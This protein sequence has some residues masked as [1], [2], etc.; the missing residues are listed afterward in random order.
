MKNNLLKSSLT[1]IAVSAL[2]IVTSRPTSAA[3]V[4]IGGIAFDDAK[5]A[6]SAS[7]V[8]G[9]LDNPVLAP[10]F[11]TSGS[12]AGSGFDTNKT[13]G[14]LLGYNPGGYPTGAIAP[15]FPDIGD[16]P[17]EPNV[18]RATIQ[19]TLPSGIVFNGV[20]DDFIIY[21]S[22]NSGAPE[23]FAV[24][25]RVAGASFSSFRYEFA[26]SFDS[27]NSA[28]ATGFDLANFGVADNAII[29]A[30]QI[31][32]IFSSDRVSDANGEGFV[33]Y[34]PGDPG[35]PLLG[36]PQ[37]T[38]TTYPINRLDADILYVGGLNPEPIVVPFEFS[39]G[40]GLLILSI[41][42]GF[43]YKRIQLKKSNTY[44]R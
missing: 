16:A 34:N 31:R 19:L 41:W 32:N 10:V 23:G 7:I 21:E 13:V 9:A 38:F 5:S 6:T 15:N 20:G 11:G 3:Q 26:N 8:E 27:A 40:L 22:G 17:P 18:V 28:F 39:P 1:L 12:A 25:V 37:A 36:G 33:V 29:D 43:L 4:T 35:F 14:R 2:T 42:S 30:I 44:I 24:S